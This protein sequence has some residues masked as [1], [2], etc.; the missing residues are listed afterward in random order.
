MRMR[1]GTITA[2]ALLGCTAGV[3]AEPH[4]PREVQYFGELPTL[5]R[6]AQAALVGSSLALVRHS[7]GSSR[8]GPCPPLRSILGSREEAALVEESPPGPVSIIVRGIALLLIF[9]PVLLGA[10]L[11][12]Y[13]AAF[14][15]GVWFS[16]VKRA[17]ATAGTA[18]IKWGQ[19]ASCRPDMFPEGLCAALSELH[20]QA[21]THG[22]GWTKAEV[23]RAFDQPLG[24]VFDEFDEKPVASG[25]IA[26]VHRAVLAGGGDPVAVK[27]R[28]PG[29]VERIVVDFTLMRGLAEV[30][31]RIPWLSWLNLKASV[32]QFSSTMVAQ[33]RL[34][35]EGEHLDRFAWNFGTPTWRR[36]AF[37]RVVRP[38]TRSVLVE[39][40]EPGTLVSTYTIERTL[41]MGGERLDLDLAHFVVS[42]GEDMYLKMLLCDNLMHADLHPGNILLHAP[43]DGQPRLT[44]LDVGMVARLTR[45]E[46]DAFIGLLH[47]MGA[48]DGAAAARAVLRFSE[49]QT[50]VEDGAVAAFTADMADLFVERCR[51]F[52]TGVEFGS[53]L[54]GVLGLVRTHRVAL[55]ANYMTLVMNVLCLEGMAAA[56]LPDYNVLDAARPLLSAHRRLP[57]PLFITALPT[58]R[59]IKG[60]RDRWWLRQVRWLARRRAKSAPPE[61]EVMRMP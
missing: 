39:T 27:V 31:A 2:L 38:P 43:A 55:D 57:R 20:S 58:L 11:A 59:R 14:R 12:L 35:I 34:D 32:A 23:E 25:S 13:W 29:V 48:G 46:S 54:R 5:P 50:C 17:L 60:V 7:I 6:S 19:W 30:T 53:V 52:G 1:R 41:N 44:L 26:Q 4:S 40:F 51:G 47:A 24:Q 8:R 21:P 33:T 9:L 15:E 36:C 61:G 42:L 16:L 37:P 49:A 22:F 56:L 10:P 3:G 18:F 45:S 28:H